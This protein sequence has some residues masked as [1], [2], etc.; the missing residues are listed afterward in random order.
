MKNIILGDGITGYIIAACLNYNDEKFKIYGNG[1]YSPPAILLL[2]YRN[3]YELLTYFD[4]FEIPYTAKNIDKYTKSIK[5]G[6]TNDF[7]TI[8]DKPTPEMKRNY[9]EKQNREATPSAMSDDLSTFH[10]IDLKLVY[11][12]LKKK[13]KKYVIYGDIKKE[14]FKNL[15]GCTVYNTIFPTEFNNNE[16]SIEYISVDKTNLKGY[17][18]IYDCNK[19]SR[20]KR[21]TPEYVE[22]ISNPGHYDFTIKNYYDA[23][24]IYTITDPKTQSTWIDIGRNATHTQTKQ[25]DVIKYIVKYE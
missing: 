7:K 22:Y 1:K 2:K 21:M 24:R 14:K 18:Y 12:H 13:Y 10:G 19:N 15:V 16:P 3:Q 11:E 25:E 23:P 9:L 5:V 20:I 8:L 4:I 17:N 6:Y